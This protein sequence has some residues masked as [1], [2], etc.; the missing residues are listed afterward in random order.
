MSSEVRGC[1]GGGGGGGGLDPSKLHLK[2][3]LN[4]IRKAARVLRDP[5]TTS[6]WRSPLTSSSRSVVAAAAAAVPS[7]SSSAWKQG[8][9]ESA[10]RHS[11]GKTQQPSLRIDG[12]SNVTNKEK[13]VFLHNWRNGYKSSSDRSAMAASDIDVPGRNDDADDGSSAPGSLED[14]LIDALNGGGD[15]KS[16]TCVGDRHQSLAFR[17]RDAN[18]V[19]LGTHS[20]RRTTNTKKK[21]KKGLTSSPMLKQKQQRKQQQKQIV[22]SLHSRM[23]PLGSSRD[24][25]ASLIDQ[26]DDT[27]EYCNSEDLRRISAASPLLL[28]LG[29]KN[30]SHPSSKFLSNR[31]KED[32]S[33]SYSTP[34]LSTSSY[35]QYGNRNPST[36]GSWDGTTASFNDGDDEVDDHLD[37]PGRQGCGIPCY[38]SKRTPKHRGPCRSCYSPSF[39]DTLRRKGSRIFCGSQNMYHRRR[40]SLSNNRRIASRTAQGVLPLL[41]NNA[42]GGGGSSMGSGHSDDELSTNFGELDLEALS[43]LDGRRWSSSCR[44]Q[45]A[46]ELQGGGG[47]EEGTPENIRSLSQKYRP[48]FFDELIG[49]NIVVQSLMNAISRGRIAPVYLFQ[50]PRGTGKTSTA[51]IFAAALNCLA[52]EETKPCGEC[53]ECTDFISGKSRDLKEVDG[54]NKKAIDR[55]KCLLKNLSVGPQSA[56][57][58]YKVFVID[59]CHLLP[60]KTWLAFLKFLEEPPP[61]VVFIFITTD[62]DSVPRPIL[63]RCQ[64]YLFNKIKDCDVVARLRKISAEEN[65]DVEFDA[66]DLIALNADGSL[67]DAETMLDQLSLLGKRIT[68]SLVNELVGVVSDDKLLELLELALSSDTAETVKR[69]REL[70]D[71]G[72]DPMV[73][74]SQMASLIMDLIAGTY[75]IV[76]M[77]YSDS[78]VGG[79]SLTETELERLKNALRLLSEAEKQLRVSSER[80]TWFTAM[81]LQ[82]GSVPSSDFTQSS[83]SRRQSS[84]TTDDDPSSASRE[85]AAQK[86]KADSQCMP[87]K[88]TSSSLSLPYHG[89]YTHQGDLLSPA[90]NFSFNSRPTHS[91]LVNGSASAASYD[92]FM[93]GNMIFR[94]I[95]SEKLVDIWGRCIERCH[96][97]TLRQLLHAHGKL[98][99]ISEV[100]GILVAYI[101]FRDGDI[102][103]RAERFLSSITDSI[104]TVLRCN[105]EVRII[106]LSD[107]EAS[108]TD[109]QLPDRSDLKQRE[110]STNRERKEICSNAG[111]SDMDFH[112]DPI[113]LSKGS[114]S[115]AADKLKAGARDHSNCSP[116]L[117]DGTFQATAGS[118]LLSAEGRTDIRDMKERKQEI[119][120]QRIESVISEQRLETAW[121]QATEKGTPVSMGRL[122]PE[123]NQVLPQDGMCRQNQMEPMNSVDLSSGYWE[124]G[125][126]HDIKVLK[127]NDG[128]IQKDQIGKRVDHYPIS[129]SLLHDSSLAGNFSKDN[130]GYE[131]GSGTGGCSGLFCWN[132]TKH[133]RKA[134]VNQGATVE[135]HKAGRFL[136][137]GECGIS[138]KTENRF[139]K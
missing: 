74:M 33:Y 1:I 79:R 99:S 70:M 48:V 102:K 56:F 34:A 53:R 69:A 82:L 51:R 65:L 49:Q 131:S 109:F 13:R 101:A 84:K 39:S 35:N 41:T 27:E 93:V 67:R 15:S 16:D 24:E 43:R 55:I 77:K 54:T 96:S 114:F 4:Q 8:E 31:R 136:W 132:N 38:W 19:S 73:L 130:L 87:R 28:K 139:R 85:A 40:R 37:L 92:D 107:G 45:D 91:P 76:D 94:C 71:S 23:L 59:E 9:T 106:L 88:S 63:S 113:K 78:F 134:K 6:T 17:C 30:W 124:D 86:Q 64:K 104:E 83:S 62:L 121:L 68:T 97:K 75:R 47:E 60:S 7:S 128:R 58:R 125:L 50:G 95:N 129:P 18:V 120:L 2:K 29:N 72:V 42:D 127:I 32:S 14:S 108:L 118:P 100:E 90:D 12:I 44:S 52:T 135:S 111:Y 89:N 112:Q 133:H 81:L 119:P 3:E 115:D 5:G 126:N 117:V 61:R 98:V 26:S 57:S 10:R 46:L 66:L 36:V 25:T 138:K 20:I 21:P 137:F 22:H 116:S 103:S 80:S 11:N 105:V 110:L 122:K 123:K